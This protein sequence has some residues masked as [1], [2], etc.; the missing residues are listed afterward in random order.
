MVFCTLFMRSHKYVNLPVFFGKKVNNEVLK[1]TFS[2][3][4]IYGGEVG[5]G[6]LNQ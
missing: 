2:L 3:M 1:N 5:W 6:L 4:A